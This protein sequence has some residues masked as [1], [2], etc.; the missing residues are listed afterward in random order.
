[1][2][3]NLF[4]FDFDGTLFRSPWPPKG[5][6]GDPDE[7]WRT[8]GSLDAPCVPEKPSSEWWNEEVVSAAKKA[9]A[10]RKNNVV[11][12]MTGRREEFFEARL[13]KLLA[14]KGLSF[15]YVFMKGLSTTLSY[16]M[17]NLQ[18]LIGRYSPTRVEIW[19]DRKNHLKKLVEFVRSFEIEVVGHYVEDRPRP[20]ACPLE[21]VM[22]MAQNQRESAFSKRLYRSKVFDES[23]LTKEWVEGVRKGIALEMESKRDR[24]KFGKRLY[25][26]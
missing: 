23:E 11:V 20:V 6:K 4:I 17:G 22:A 5:W 24:D 10:D 19:D 21:T 1:M 25:D 2:K 7:W 8:P 13:S 3:P 16:K 12:L 14:Q 26:I 9:H 18:S 15:D